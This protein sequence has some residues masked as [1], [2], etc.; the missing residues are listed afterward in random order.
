[1]KRVPWAIQIHGLAFP[2]AEDAAAEEDYNSEC[3]MEIN[4]DDKAL[5]ALAD[6]CGAKSVE[7][8]PAMEEDAGEPP[9]PANSVFAHN[10][11]GQSE[12]PQVHQPSQ[13][14]LEAV[15]WLRQRL[16]RAF[17]S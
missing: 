16:S 3:P 10:P 2:N 17:F 12:K 8:M 13:R 1:M 11:Y 14:Q 6:H 15:A 4:G 5:E 7:A 9:H